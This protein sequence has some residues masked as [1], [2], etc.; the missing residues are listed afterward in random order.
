MQRKYQWYRNNFRMEGRIKN[1]LDAFNKKTYCFLNSWADSSVLLSSTVF[2]IAVDNIF[3]VVLELAKSVR[4]SISL[5][6][7]ESRQN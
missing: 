3:V 5:F 2:Q 4:V 7:R 1:G 6:T